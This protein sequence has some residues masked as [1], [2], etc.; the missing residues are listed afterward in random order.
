MTVD[1]I[2]AIAT[3]PGRGGVGIIRLSG[4]QAYSIAVSLNGNKT[5]NPRLATFCSFYSIS[6][7]EIL[8]PPH[9]LIDQGIMIYFKAPTLS[10]ERMLLKSRLMDLL[11]FW[12]CSPKLAFSLAR[13]WPG[14]ESF[15]NALF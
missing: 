10:L 2:V 3:P 13:G 6:E 9:S 14:Q 8:T 5:L 7:K 1:T 11:W 12:I 15:Q 4:P